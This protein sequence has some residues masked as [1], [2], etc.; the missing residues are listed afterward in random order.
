MS[1]WDPEIY[2]DS[3]EQIDK[4]KNKKRKRKIGWIIAKWLE[5]IF[6]FVMAFLEY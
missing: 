5:V 1:R 2:G 6:E 3:N 4:E